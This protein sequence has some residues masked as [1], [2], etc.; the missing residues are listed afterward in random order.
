MALPIADFVTTT[1]A[2]LLYH[3]ASCLSNPTAGRRSD[4]LFPEATCLRKP[5]TPTEQSS[6]SSSPP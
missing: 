1:S 2:S 6:E 4:C 3:H 5:T